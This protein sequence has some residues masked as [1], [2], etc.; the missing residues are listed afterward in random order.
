[1]QYRKMPKT[2]DPV[3][4]LGYGC[5]RLPIKDGAIDEPRAIRQLRSA[6]DQGVNYMDT[7]W[8]YH[9]GESERLL[10]KALQDGYRQKVRIATKL[11]CWLIKSRADMDW[12]LGEQLKKLQTD[13]IDYYL[14]HAL[15]SESWAAVRDLGAL[16]FLEAAKKDGRI[17]NA[18]FSFHG[19][20]EDFAP[21]VDAYPWEFCQIQY[22]Y[23]DRDYQAGTAGLQ[24]AASKSIGVV[25]ME[26]LR[27]GNLCPP[28][29]PASIQDLWN[30][31]EIKRTPAEWALRWIWNQPEVTTILSGMNDE[32]Q[33]TQNLA[34]AD[35]ARIGEL[36][37]KEL[38]LVDRVAEQYRKLIRVGCTN[39]G[40][41]LPCPA[42]VLIPKCFEEYNN[43][44]MF[45]ANEDARFRYTIATSGVISGGKP[46]FAS[47]CVNC[48][49]CLEKCPQQIPIPEILKQVVADLEGADLEKRVA[50]VRQIFKDR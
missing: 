27:G 49:A 13:R 2:K 24:Y 6:I 8:P 12:F 34:L 19:K 36:T 44:H 30:E 37:Q 10:G 28:S 50:A 25:I 38:T 4:I 26:P 18:G 33:I 45:Q 40:Y 7:A 29:P 22:N 20:S 11:P 43:F 42:D 47:Q 21:I 1:M 5:M 17:G 48:G 32:S 15:N 23:L 31:S 3:S 46:G 16:D 9:G 39:C 35:A 14:L 41:C